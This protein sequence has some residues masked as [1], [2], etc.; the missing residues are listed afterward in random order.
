MSARR[1]EVCEEGLVLLVRLEGV[2]SRCQ[3]LR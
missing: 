3:V 1:V 2:V